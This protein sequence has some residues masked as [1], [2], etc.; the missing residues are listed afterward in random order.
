MKSSINGSD[1]VNPLEEA[2]RLWIK[3]RDEWATLIRRNPAGKDG[4]V[5][6][7]DVVMDQRCPVQMSIDRMSGYFSV[8]M[9]LPLWIAEKDMYDGLRLVNHINTHIV[10][11]NVEINKDRRIRISTGAKPYDTAVTQA[12]FENVYGQAVSIA[13]RFLNP[14]A[15]VALS[16][17]DVHSLMESIDHEAANDQNANGPEGRERSQKS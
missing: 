10:A 7:E 2:M 3:Q 14:L 15:H 5:A 13:S 12:F 1:P 8:W 4:C 11:G 16:A 17:S 9:S 6:V